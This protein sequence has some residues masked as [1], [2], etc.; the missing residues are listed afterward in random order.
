MRRLLPL[1]LLALVVFFAAPSAQTAAEKNVIGAW[2][3]TYS[4]DGT[5]KYTMTIAPDA[6]KKLG[7]TLTNTNESG[8]SFTS[9]FKT[10]TVDGPKLSISYESPG[11][12]G[13]LVQLDATIEKAS[14]TGA[15]KVVDSAKN[16]MQS[17]TFTGTKEKK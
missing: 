1:I 9:T 11:D 2:S 16:V 13:G 6:S 4:G 10:V 17:G 7:G 15:W 5:G 8:E 3:G 12:D 14:L